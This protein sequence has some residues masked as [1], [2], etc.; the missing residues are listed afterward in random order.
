MINKWQGLLRS[1]QTEVQIMLAVLFS[2]NKGKFWCIDC[3][4]LLICFLYID[5]QPNSAA[6][7]VQ[8]SGPSNRGVLWK[9]KVLHNFLHYFHLFSCIHVLFASSR[10]SDS[11]PQF[12][13]FWG[14]GVEEGGRGGL[15]EGEQGE[16]WEMMRKWR[17]KWDLPTAGKVRTFCKEIFFNNQQ[18]LESYAGTKHPIWI[19]Y[20]WRLLLFAA[21]LFK[22]DPY[23]GGK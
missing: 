19:P 5:L 16:L 13:F 8:H 22:I 18:I 23:S 11:A 6:P 14:G 7:R 21:S 1:S 4:H 20:Q 12:Y 17:M 3:H 9:T 15:G 2:E 10:A